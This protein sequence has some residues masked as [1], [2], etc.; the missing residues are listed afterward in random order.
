MQAD[1]YLWKQKPGGDDEL[2]PTED[3]FLSPP[4]IKL[5]GGARQVVRLARLKPATPPEELNYRMIVREVPE[6]RPATTVQ[7]QVALAI[8][9]PIFITPPRAKAAISCTAERLSENAVNAVCGNTG[10]AHALIANLSLTEESG[11]QLV[12]RDSGGYILPGIKRGFELKRAEGAIPGGK[13][14]LSVTL[15]DGSRQAFDVLIAGP[16]NPA[17]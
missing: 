2:T 14:K 7:V 12:T 5:A 6:A 3:L 15:S 17:Q 13:G 16:Q 4:I 8:S 11:Q 9:L 10:S 1:L